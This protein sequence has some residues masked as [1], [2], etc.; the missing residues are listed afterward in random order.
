MVRAEKLPVS[1]AVIGTKISFETIVISACYALFVTKQS[2]YSRHPKKYPDVDVCFAFRDVLGKNDI[3]WVVLAT[4]VE[5]HFSIAP[6]V[7]LSIKHVFV[8]KPLELEEKE[9]KLLISPA[10]ERSKVL[11]TPGN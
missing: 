5:T 2:D 8:E 6:E 7:L 4:P 9:A 1:A 3:D 11:R 10:G